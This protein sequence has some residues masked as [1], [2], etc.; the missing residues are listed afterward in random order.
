MW[1]FL[2]GPIRGTASIVLV[3]RGCHKRGDREPVF[4]GIDSDVQP[5][6]VFPICSD[7]N[8]CLYKSRW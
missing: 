2:W 8:M 7:V 6:R 5:Y 4:G 1:L 3:P